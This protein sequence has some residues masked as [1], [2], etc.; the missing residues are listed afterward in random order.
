VLL[1]RQ[2]SA[3][4][5]KGDFVPGTNGGVPVARD[6]RAKGVFFA[7]GWDLWSLEFFNGLLSFVLS[8]TMSF[9]LVHGMF[10]AGLSS[11]LICSV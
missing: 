8:W 7:S 11:G 1:G 4:G 2:N 5:R 3:A 6:T 10:S 9:A